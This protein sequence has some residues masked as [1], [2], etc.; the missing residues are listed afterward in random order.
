M[1]QVRDAVYELTALGISVQSPTDPR[2]V[3]QIDEFIF[4]A[5]DH[6]R[7]VPT[8]QRLHLAA[9]SRSDFLW[10]VAPDG[11]VGLSASLEIGYAAACSVP[12]FAL[13]APL[14]QTVTHFVTVVPKLADVP[15][16]LRTLTP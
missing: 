11:Y 2:V 15:L 12:V 6:L 13:H 1:D 5:S 10:L 16:L 14:D 4:V 3:D 9:I 8:V 7:S